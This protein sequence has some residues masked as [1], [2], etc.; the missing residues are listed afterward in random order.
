MN[1]PVA[2]AWPPGLGRGFRIG[3]R[4]E[5]MCH[6][7]NSYMKPLTRDHIIPRSR[8]GTNYSWNLVPACRPCN[9]AKGQKLPTCKCAFCQNAIDQHWQWIMEH[10]GR[11]AELLSQV[12]DLYRNRWNPPDSTH[13]S[14]KGST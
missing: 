14:Q 13:L 6:Y 11:R 1:D 4:R 10:R 7:C 9:H 2:P 5:F 12:E 8:G 3:S